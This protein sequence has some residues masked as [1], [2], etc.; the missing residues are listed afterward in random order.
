M[1]GRKAYDT[2]NVA[3][4]FGIRVTEITAEGLQKQMAKCLLSYLSTAS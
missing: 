3:N 4:D 1:T 2:K